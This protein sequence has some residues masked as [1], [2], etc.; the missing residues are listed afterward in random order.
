MT[1]ATTKTNHSLADLPPGSYAL[2]K[3]PEQL[4]ASGIRRIKRFDCM[5]PPI[6]CVHDVP[7]IWANQDQLFLVWRERDGKTNIAFLKPA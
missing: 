3:S 4:A 5:N 7:S 6:D 2:L 1:N